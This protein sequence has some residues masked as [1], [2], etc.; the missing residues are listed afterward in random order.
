MKTRTRR[1]LERLRWA[2]FAAYVLMGFGA[3]VGL[4]SW[5]DASLV[6]LVVLAPL[7]VL[8]SVLIAS[9]PRG[10]ER[11]LDLD[12]KRL[13]VPWGRPIGWFQSRRLDTR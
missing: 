13:G 6:L 9:G 7:M 12:A 8:N 3:W 11:P 1:W 2:L 10:R 4:W 5:D